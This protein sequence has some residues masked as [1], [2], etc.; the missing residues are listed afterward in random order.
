MGSGFWILNFVFSL[1]TFDSHFIGR[2]IKFRSKISYMKAPKD[3]LK[4]NLRYMRKRKNLSQEDLAFRLKISRGKL[5]ALE[6]GISKNPQMEDLLKFS[7]FF[8]ITV[9]TLLK[10]DLSQ[11]SPYKMKLIEAGDERYATGTEVRVLALTVDGNDCENMEFV[12]IKAK[13]GYR[14]HYNDPEFISTL[15]RFTLPHLPKNKTFRMFP[16]TGDSMLPIPAGAFVIGSYVADWLQLKDGTLCI[17]IL[18]GEQDFVFKQVFHAAQEEKALRLK[19]LNEAY[20][21]YEVSLRD[22]LEI[23]QFHSYLTDTLPAPAGN[24]EQ[25]AATVTTIKKDVQTL[26]Q[27]TRNKPE[28]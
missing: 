4:N 19:S 11:L 8:S 7:E 17:L 24:L 22:V 6:N 23:W 15:P 28:L 14:S 3:F 5:N 10:V 1:L 25:I 27:A 13:A 16:T 21:P 18:K 12:P 9:D 20:E 2:M 26:L